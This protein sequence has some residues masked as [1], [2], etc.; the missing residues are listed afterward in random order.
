MQWENTPCGGFTQPGVTPWLRF[1]DLSCNVAD[2]RDDPDSLLTL[3]RDLIALR[4]SMPDLATGAWTGA[5]A[6][7]GVLAYRRGD[8]CLVVLNLGDDVATV[9]G[10]AGSILIGTRRARDAA[11]VTGSLT[12]APAEAVILTT[13]AVSA[14]NMTP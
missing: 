9:D 6:P 2:Q 4:T 3:T 8:H 7:E 14:S 1:G 10:V 11:P 13:T 5:D 12:L